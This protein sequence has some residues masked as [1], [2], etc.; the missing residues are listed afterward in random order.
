MGE[1]KREIERERE[2][3][4]NAADQSDIRCSRGRESDE[5]RTVGRERGD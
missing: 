5:K 4:R 3:W 2:G 1:A